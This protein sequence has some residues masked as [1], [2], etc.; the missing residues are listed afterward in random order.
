M[1]SPRAA[2]S[3]AI[4]RSALPERTRFITRVALP[5]FHA[6]VQRLGAV[7]VRVERLDERVDLE[8]RAAEDDAPSV[9]SSMS[10][11]R[12]SAA[13]FWARRTM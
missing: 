5:L 9:G 10:R 11:M 13:G 1:S 4:S 2:T 6:A 3:V 7:A 8:P 12:S